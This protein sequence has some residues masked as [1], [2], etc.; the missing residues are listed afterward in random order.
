MTPEL[1]LNHNRMQQNLLRMRTQLKMLGVSFRPHVKTAK[2]A[3]VVEQMVE[4]PLGPIT[5]STVRE[6]QEMAACG[7]RDI[8]YAVGLS[9]NKVEPVWSLK[10]QGI[11][12]KVI[13]DSMEMVQA[14]LAKTQGSLDFL[15]EIDSDDHRA[16]LKPGHPEIVEIARTLGQAGHRV[17][18]VMTHAGGSYSSQNPGEL[19][20]WAERERAAVVQAADQLREIGTAVSIV[21]LGST[22]TALFAQD[23][24]GVTEVRAGVY[25]F[26]DL[27]MAGLGVCE[28]DQ[29]ALS[30]RTTVI[31]QNRQKGWTLVDAGWMALSRDRGT[32]NQAYDHGYGLVCDQDGRVLEDWFVES[33]NQEH[34]IIIDRSERNRVFPLGS[35]LHILPNHACSTAAQFDAYQVEFPNQP[36]QT[37]QRFRGW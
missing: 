17:L 14:I 34:G 26:M 37:W 31:G 4:K 19:G 29:I 16:G 33:V 9:P 18:G 32:A 20:T 7:Y 28:W 2:C 35:I 22:P 15:I 25:V 8:L 21:S 5:V 1:V 24:S 27:V 23:L 11:N 13:T 3:E 6:A 12:I 10:Q 36:T 30:V